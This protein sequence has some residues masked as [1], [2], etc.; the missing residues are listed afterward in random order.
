M[1]QTEIRPS[2]LKITLPDTFA[3]PTDSPTFAAAEHPGFIAASPGPQNTAARAIFAPPD[4]LLQALSDH[5]MEVV[6]DVTLPP[7]LP[8][9]PREGRLAA[10]LPPIPDR[11]EIA[12]DLPVGGHEAAVVLLEQDGLLSWHFPTNPTETASSTAA[13]RP[14]AAILAAQPRTLS[15]RIAVTAEQA[16]PSQA[17]QAARR[18]FF[19]EIIY[20]RV[21]AIVLKFVFEAVGDIAIDAAM[22]QL[23]SRFK[24]GFCVMDGD[25]PAAWAAC[26]SLAGL[27]LPAERPARVLLFVHGTFSSTVGSFGG[28]CATP[29]G[30]AFLQATRERYDAV[31]GFD[32]PTLS[33]D[34]LQNARDLL[35]RLRQSPEIAVEF[36]VVSYSRGGLVLRSLTELLLPH[37]EY[38]TRFGSVIFIAV[39][40]AGTQLALSANWHRL[41]DL[42][43]NLAVGAAQG[44]AILA[45][46]NPLPIILPEMMQG[47]SALVKYLSHHA[48]D[49]NAVPG[50]GAMSP[51]SAFIHQL[52]DIQ[53]PIPALQ[54]V[55]Y[56]AI[57]SEFQAHLWG[58]G[59]PEP[60]PR[61]LLEWLADGFLDQLMGEDNDLVVNTKSMTEIYHEMPQQLEQ[62]YEFGPTSR[63]YH[64]NYFVQPEVTGHLVSWLVN[65]PT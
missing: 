20:R 60:L 9:T 55:K 64:L 38:Q 36:D 47:L 51:G 53:A 23:E 27:D 35:Q 52:D 2:G 26:D 14:S 19:P 6:D 10:A 31:V 43:V 16:P 4:A 32:H 42:Y 18:G 57:T 30:R 45:P 56:Y 39:T 58:A 17:S 8:P 1:P 50:L 46:G 5:E 29:E 25:D 15:F 41:A 7:A 59:D 37:D 34:P 28:L 21:R 22:K 12:F 13:L 24:R 65:I 11:Q 48:I 61:R 33:E 62:K 44:L 40:N 3:A 63:V 49:E 54:E